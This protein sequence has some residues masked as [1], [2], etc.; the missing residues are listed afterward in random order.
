MNST[1]FGSIRWVESGFWIGTNENC[2]TLLCWLKCSIRFR[3]GR[4]AVT[5]LLLLVFNRSKY[6]LHWEYLGKLS[7]S[8]KLEEI[9]LSLDFKI[10][11][12]QFV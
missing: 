7:V 1:G 4:F 10:G 11:H 6:V 2:S 9:N 3:S 8:K 5:K 12:F